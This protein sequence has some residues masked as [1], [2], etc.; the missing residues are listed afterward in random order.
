MSQLSNWNATRISCIRN[1][2]RRPR[3]AGPLAL[4]V[5]GQPSIRLAC[6]LLGTYQGRNARHERVPTVAPAALQWPA[7][8]A[9]MT[10]NIPARV[11]FLPEHENRRV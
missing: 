10:R 2:Y 3:T 9:G 11:L 5:A 6:G 4:S 8:R 1:D 7:Q